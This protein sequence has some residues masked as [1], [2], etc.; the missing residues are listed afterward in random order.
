M[1]SLRIILILGIVLLLTFILNIV[2]RSTEPAPPP[3]TAIALPDQ[4]QGEL[5]AAS[6]TVITTRKPDRPRDAPFSYPPTPAGYAAERVVDSGLVLDTVTDTSP[7][8]SPVLDNIFLDV[9]GVYECQTPS[10]TPQRAIF[11]T[12]TPGDNELRDQFAPTKQ[13]IIDWEDE[14]P[15]DIGPIIMPNFTRQQFT[16][17]VV[18]FEYTSNDVRSAVFTVDGQQVQIYYGWIL[19]YVMFAPSR[20]CLTAALNSL[21]SP[22]SH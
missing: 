15:Q 1:K 21:Y 6:S 22:S 12:A 19:N 2:L 7:S 17:V 16:D 10:P 20:G 5:D 11:F 4:V 18:D 13:A 14:L 9:Y 8:F 3:I